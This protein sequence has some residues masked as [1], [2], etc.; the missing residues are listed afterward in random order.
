MRTTLDLPDETFRRLKAQAALRGHKLKELVVDISDH[1]QPPFRRMG[2]Q[3]SGAW[4]A[5]V[6]GHVRPRFRGM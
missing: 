5:T 2:G 1:E 3:H 4:E 6:P